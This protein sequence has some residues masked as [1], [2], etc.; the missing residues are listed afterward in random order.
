MQISPRDLRLPI[1]ILA[2]A[3]AGPLFGTTV[4]NTAEVIR[5]L[6]QE[7]NGPASAFDIVG[8]VV[9]PYHR[10]PGSFVLEDASGCRRFFFSPNRIG[11]VPQNGDIVRIRGR[12]DR[13]WNDNP[14]PF[15]D[16]IDLLGH[17]PPAADPRDVTAR[18][19]TGNR[20]LD[21]RVRLRGIV[22]DA[23]AD[24]IDCRFTFLVVRDETGTVYASIQHPPGDPHRL[25]DLIG[26]HVEVTGICQLGGGNFRR[27]ISHT[28]GCRSWA[29]VRVTRP[30]P[31]DPFAVP[32]L[33]TAVGLPPDRLA[34]LGRLRTVGHVLSVRQRGT[35]LVRSAD[36]QTSRVE[37]RDKQNLPR[38]GDSIEAVGLPDTDLYHVNLLRAAWRK[39]DPVPTPPDEAEAVTAADL[40]FLGA[41][42][43]TESPRLHGRLVRLRGTVLNLSDVRAR[44][45][46]LALACGNRLVPVDIGTIR[47]EL[48]ELPVGSEVDVTGICEIAIDSWR[49]N[50][51][52]PG[53]LGF[54]L[55]PR[56]PADIRLV[57][58]PPWWTPGRLLGVIGAL[59]ALV[60]GA[61]AWNFSLRRLAERRGRQLM[62]EQAEGLSQSLKVVE[63]TRLA[64]EL[65]DTI[66]QNLMAVS[67]EIGAANRLNSAHA[68]GSSAHLSRAATMLDSCRNDLRN[69]LWDLR[70]QA[71]EESDLN[72]AILRTL[73]PHLDG[74]DVRV[75]FCARR[76]LLS[77]NAAHA[78]MMV[79]RELVLNAVKHGRAKRIRISGSVENERLLFAVT[80]D[81][82]G[83]DPG[84][85]P[86][87]GQGHF[88]LQGVRERLERFGGTMNIESRAGRGTRVSAS[89]RLTRSESRKP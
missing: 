85:R 81:G 33:A 57:T 1:G 63:R 75:R 70:S 66:A 61:F 43:T 69:C 27:Q 53:I 68:D 46:T 34:R 30:A 50:L 26:A 48:D 18:D 87:V 40:P 71:L 73:E 89:L 39:A 21:R 19:I 38:P 29:D 49:P 44:E 67:L 13:I 31:P 8:T 14:V 83:F 80:D 41:A 86:D 4:T 52:F 56:T 58:L 51:P 72:A 78:L 9:P 42:T 12:I 15:I 45:Q 23:F 28:I 20:A 22:H 55:V 84:A 54:T 62:A 5:S 7:P 79:I 64:V 59:L 74:T 25:Q 36:G 37:L 6:L 24:E 88:G 77:D 10:S 60:V 32:S 3:V 65:H 35:M 47:A 16:A 82:C 17:R 11:R 76:E 2:V